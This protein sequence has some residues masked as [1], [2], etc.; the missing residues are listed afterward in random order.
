MTRKRN[1]RRHPDDESSLGAQGVID[2]GE[3]EDLEKTVKYA[4]HGE[5]V[6]NERGIQSEASELSGIDRKTG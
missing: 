1:R 3:K 5:D 4:V 2:S 6:P